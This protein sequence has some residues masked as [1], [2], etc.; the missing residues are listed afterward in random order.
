MSL[1]NSNQ[2]VQQLFGVSGSEALRTK[3]NSFLRNGVIPSSLIVDDGFS[4][5]SMGKRG[6]KWFQPQAVDCLFNAL[7]LD[8]FFDD[9]QYVKAIFEVPATRRTSANLCEEIL[10]KAQTVSAV[11]HLSGK[12]QQ[13]LCEMREPAFNLRAARLSCPFEAQ[14]LPQMD[15]ALRH[16]GLLYELLRTQRLSLSFKEQLLLCWLEQDL[17]GAVTL[18]DQLEPALLHADVALADLVRRV[19]SE[20]QE[21]LSFNVLLNL[22]PD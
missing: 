5:P 12:A 7:V 16:T 4:D 6:K 8:A 2:A 20:Y 17:T 14:R 13:F 19:R 11:G 21:A 9:T 18:A 15:M 10:L 22:L 3:A 1:V